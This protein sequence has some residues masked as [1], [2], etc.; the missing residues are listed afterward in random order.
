MSAW[1][2]R[3]EIG[4]LLLA[5][6]LSA[7]AARRWH[8]ALPAAPSSASTLGTALSIPA[9]VEE[10]SLAAAREL[11]AQSDPFRLSRTPATVPFTRAAPPSALPMGQPMFRPNLVLKGIVG[12]P[13]W[14][15]VIDGLPGQPA[16]TVVKAG[17]TFDK[18]I[19]RSISRDTVVVQSPDSTWR[20]TLSKG[21][22]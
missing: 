3:L 21:S 12:G 14:Q 22:T 19:I 20:L 9:S 11:G 17:G 8:N 15:A 16:G 4:L 2:G 13:P 6:G 1:I 5:L 10:D 7:V 18:L